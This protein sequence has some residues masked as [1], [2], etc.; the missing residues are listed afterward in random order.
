MAIC[1]PLLEIDRLSLSFQ[2]YGQQYQVLHEV[3]LTLAA[4]E[5]VALIGESGSGKSVTGK[6]LIGT[7]PAAARILSGD[8]RLEGQSLLTLPA[9]AREALKGSKMSMIQQDPL[10]SFNPVFRIGTHLDDVMRFVARQQGIRMS[11]TQ[12]RQ[13]IDAVL[14]KVRLSDPQR[15]F[16]AYPWQL[17]G[18]MRQR[19]LIAMAL[20]HPTRILIADEPGTALDVTTQA[21]INTLINRLVDEEQLALLLITHN[22]GVVR[23]CADRVYVMQQGRIVEHTSAAALCS[24]PHHPYTRRLFHAVPRL[25]G[26]EVR[27]P[28]LPRGELCIDISDA[29]K[30]FGQQPRWLRKPAAAVLAVNHVSLRIQ[31]GDIFGLA[32][33]SGS[34]KTTLARAVMGLLP[35]SAGSITLDG[36]PVT[37]GSRAMSKKIQLVHQNPAM[38]LNPK[39]T[40][41]DALRVPLKYLCGYQG[42]LTPRVHQ[43]LRQVE[44]PPEYADLY[45]NNLSGGQKQRVAIARALAAEPEVLVL[46][47]PTSALDVSVQ[48]SVITLLQRLQQE[49]GLT[50]LF[51]SHDLSLMRNFC[52]H[53][54]VMLKGELVESGATDRVFLA[55]QHAYTQALLQAIPVLTE[56]EERQKPLS[57]H[58]AAAERFHHN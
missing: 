32:G 3:S 13:H 56:E 26:D 52:N 33:E 37:Y 55:P 31:R 38:S 2:R 27:A 11:Q 5:R 46:D 35:L 29:V 10:T 47:E 40:V 57:A 25:Y 44:L 15:V 28:V 21:E 12:R 42:D 53:V 54:A 14:R 48:F 7:L 24:H 41:G 16:Q 30:R 22:L 39:R 49:L 1:A 8:I 9:A 20:L 45:P 19:V 4:G 17:S 51:I 34:G 23:Q 50:Y 6:A 36:Q 18:G 43:L 58:P